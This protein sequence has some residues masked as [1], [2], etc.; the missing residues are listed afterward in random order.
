[1]STPQKS[2]AAVTATRPVFVIGTGRSGTHWLGYSLGNHPEVHATIEVE[3]MF[4]LST[5]MALNVALEGKLFRQLVRAY[6][7][8]LSQCGKRIYLDKS[9]PN[10]WLAEKLKQTFPDGLFVGIE[11]NPYATVASMIKH[12]GV[13][14]WHG[15]WREFPVPNRFLGI[16]SELAKTYDA[17]PLAAQCAWRWVAHHRRMNQL[18]KTLGRD[19]MVISY[20]TF[21]HQTKQTVEQLQKFL[22]LQTPIPIPDVKT[23]SL[24]KWTS[25]LSFDDVKQIENVVG[26]PPDARQSA[27]A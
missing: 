9:H 10:I 22:G 5:K 16:T 21:A 18:S 13:A 23:D 20:E 3:P 14:A 26:F 8:Q 1:M 4:G 7:Q 6:Q 27:A 15:R 25:D 19:L 17:L 24:Q 11:R 2:T 12:R